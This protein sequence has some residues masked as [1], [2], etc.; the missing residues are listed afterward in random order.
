MANAL[1]DHSPSRDVH[2]KTN[3]TPEYAFVLPRL[4]TFNSVLG[5]LVTTVDGDGLGTLDDILLDLKNGRVAYAIVSSG[6][7]MGKGER[8]YP[9]PW[10]A[11][12]RDTD[13]HCFVLKTEKRSFLNAPSFDK[14]QWQ[15]ALDSALRHGLNQ[16]YGTRP[17]QL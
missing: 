14:R 8:F 6:G 3:D 17:Y 5:D 2:E 11:M 9:V 13:R 4:T 15:S 1:I 10:D 12:S 7:F 16:I